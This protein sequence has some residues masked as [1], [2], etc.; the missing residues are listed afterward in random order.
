MATI[1]DLQAALERKTRFQVLG[2][3]ESE[4]QLRLMG[5]QPKDQMGMNTAGWLL[6]CTNLLKRSG[7][8]G[9][10]VDVSKHHFLRGEMIIYSWRLIF[11]AEVELKS[12]YDEIVRTI[13]QAPQASRG[14]VTEMP[15]VGARPDRN[16]SGGIGRGKGAT[17]TPG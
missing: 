1:R 16:A 14:E 13:L 9:W 17:G 3:T 5:R 12:K 15:L 7:K 4:T 6:V 11:Q 10:T 2:H 8:S